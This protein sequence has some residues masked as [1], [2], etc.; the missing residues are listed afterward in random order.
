MCRALGTR[1]APP[2]ISGSPAAGCWAARCI[3]TA[4][5]LRSGRFCRS[6][7]VVWIRYIADSG[8]SQVES[9]VKELDC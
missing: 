3:A 2:C 4:A 7:Q 9:Q 8:Q 5:A 6:T 1:P